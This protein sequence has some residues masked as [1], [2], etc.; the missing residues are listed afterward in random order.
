S[1]A[2]E[3]RGYG[4]SDRVTRVSTGRM[5]TLVAALTGLAASAFLISTGRATFGVSILIG[6]VLGGYVLLRTRSTDDAWHPTR[7]RDI[8]PTR[9]DRIVGGVAIG[10]IAAII[11]IN[12]WRPEAIQYEPYPAISWPSVSLPIISVIALLMAPV[13]LAPLPSPERTG[14]RR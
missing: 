6:T 12:S 11:A 9:N 4:G 3:S 7:Y 14:L 10:A 5:L 8:V 13:F 2:L 1:E